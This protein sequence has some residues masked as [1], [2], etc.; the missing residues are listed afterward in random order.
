MRQAVLEVIGADRLLYG[1]NFNGSDFV[2]D[3]LT[4]GLR[5]S[6]ADLDKIRF[7]NAIDLLH[8]DPAKLGRASVSETEAA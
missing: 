5:C 4:R 8:L 7:G 2:R 6:Q 3:D 1:T